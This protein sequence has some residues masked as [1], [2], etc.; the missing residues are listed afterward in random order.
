MKKRELYKQN[1]YPSF[2]PRK[3]GDGQFIP[4]IEENLDV[5]MSSES[6][7]IDADINEIKLNQHNNIAL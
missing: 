2:D 5:S 6:F 1:I 4:V 3:V 7:I